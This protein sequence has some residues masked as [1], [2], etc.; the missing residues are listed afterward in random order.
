LIRE[1]ALATYYDEIAVEGMRLAHED[2]ARVAVTGDRL[3]LLR[4]SAL[5]LVAQLERVRSPVPFSRSFL[6]GSA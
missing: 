2:V 5:G 3:D 1:R 4:G 6:R